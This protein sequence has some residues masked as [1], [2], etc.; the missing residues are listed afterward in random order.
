MKTELEL[1][2]K[3][4]TGQRP[5]IKNGITCPDCGE[6]IRT[7]DYYESGYIEFLIDK[8]KQYENGNRH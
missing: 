2:Y 6:F 5:S 7:D 8:I 3:K 1:E 4:E